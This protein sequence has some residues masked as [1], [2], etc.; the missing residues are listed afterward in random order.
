MVRTNYS[1]GSFDI[2]FVRSTI[3]KY[4]LAVLINIGIEVVSQM[5]CFAKKKEKK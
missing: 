2:S 3:Q 5:H 4:I 1:Q